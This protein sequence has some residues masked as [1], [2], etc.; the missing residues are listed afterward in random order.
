MDYYERALAIAGPE[1]TLGRA[2]GAGARR[3]GR[4]ALL[5]GR[6]PR[7]DARS[8]ERA[9]AL[10]TE[11]DD[12]WTLALALR[13]RGDIAINVDADLDKAEELLARSLA[14]A[15]RLDEPWAIAR[16]LLFPGWVPWTRDDYDEA[17]AIWRRALEL[18]RDDEDRWAEVRALTS[19]SIN[20]SQQERGRDRARA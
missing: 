19:L 3:D 10:G 17:D 15:E 9:V 8:L 4:G 1:D 6:V 5:A 18:A 2:R 14:A 7:G 20:H 16:T 11:L 13:F 12:A